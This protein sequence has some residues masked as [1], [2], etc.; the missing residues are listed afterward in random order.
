LSPQTRRGRAA[1]PSHRKPARQAAATGPAEP[2]EEIDDEQLEAEKR[3]VTGPR[4]RKR[5]STTPV[6]RKRGLARIQRTAGYRYANEAVGAYV[7][8]FIAFCV[9][10]GGVWAWISF[11]PH[12]PTP[13]QNWTQFEETWKPKRDADLQSVSAAVAASDYK[14]LIAAYKATSA[15][16]K[17][18]MKDLS[19]VTSWESPTS[20]YL[21]G[22][23]TATSLVG[24]LISD[25]NSEASLLD[26]VV[27]STTMSDVASFKSQIDGDDQTFLADY[28]AARS[29]IL[30]PPAQ[31]SFGPTLA[32]P[33]QCAPA[34]S[35]SPEASGSPAATAT[36]TALVSGSPSA[37]GSPEASGPPCIPVPSGSPAASG[38]VSP[39]ASPSDAGSVAPSGS[40]GP[41]VAPSES[42]AAKGS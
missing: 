29:A 37:S 15:D 22:A 17:G 21:T 31:P 25:G 36:A 10:F 33:E 28:E 20:S 4:P 2:A 34:P 27:Q 38:S 26:A 30:G 11:G 24:T 16:T 7:P 5:E 14:A 3:D 32:A 12:A 6:R 18:W 40:A 8:L 41:S 9:I 23:P 19:S 42:P 13:A 1:P 39:S 35:G